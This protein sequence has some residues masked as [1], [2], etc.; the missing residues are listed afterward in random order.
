M[1]SE[2]A[3]RSEPR[4]VLKHFIEYFCLLE[5]LL[6]TFH[7]SSIFSELYERQG[8]VFWSERYEIQQ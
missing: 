8:L 7:L 1:S 3:E 6:S 2:F 5:M 4:N